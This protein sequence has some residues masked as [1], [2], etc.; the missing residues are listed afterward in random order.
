MGHLLAGCTHYRKRGQGLQALWM[1]KKPPGAAR[2]KKNRP[3]RKVGLLIIESFSPS[4]PFI[5]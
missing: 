3:Y 4:F 5:P 2:T 1:T